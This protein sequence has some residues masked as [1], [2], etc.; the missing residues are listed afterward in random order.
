M[1]GPR[2]VYA[3]GR[4]LDPARLAGLVGI[5]GA[6]V[7][8][9][10]HRDLVAVISAA[11]P[12]EAALTARLER[13]DELATVAEAHHTVVAAIATQTVVVPFRL[14]TIYQD[15]HRV[16]E[17]LCQRYDEFDALLDRLAGTVEIGVK[18]YRCPKLA[19]PCV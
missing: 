4:A 18:L 3:I 14:A 8:C 16:R 11:R 5:D 6:D 2:Y 15:E 10:A 1:T 12:D 9:V 13:L 7:H 17:L 19:G